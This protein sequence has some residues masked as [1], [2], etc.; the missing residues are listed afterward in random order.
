MA[1]TSCKLINLNKNILFYRDKTEHQ[2]LALEFNQLAV[3]EGMGF[4]HVAVPNYKNCEVLATPCHE[5]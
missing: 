3:I 2:E 1:F 5:F 4:K